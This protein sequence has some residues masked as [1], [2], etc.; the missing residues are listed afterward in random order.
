MYSTPHADAATV[1]VQETLPPKNLLKEKIEKIKEQV[2][3][4]DNY[5][6]TE[7]EQVHRPCGVQTISRQIT[8]NTASSSSELVK[9]DVDVER[10]IVSRAKE[11]LTTATQ[12]TPKSAP[13]TPAATSTQSQ[14]AGNKIDT[15]DMSI[16]TAQI[17]NKIL[18]RPLLIKDLDFTDL[19]I[20]DDIEVTRVSTA[21]PPP[22][23]MM[24]FS[25]F[26]GGPPP[27]PPMNGLAGFAGGPPPPPPPPPP[28]FMGAPPPPPP[29]NFKPMFPQSNTLPANFN[30]HTMAKHNEEADQE[31]RK[32]I[33]LHWREAQIPQS[34]SVARYAAQPAQEESI[35]TNLNH[36]DI[37]REKLAHLFE[38]KQT[39][40]KTKV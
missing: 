35:W 38:L 12:Q 16:D 23:P 29:P 13:A 30:S 4:S 22:P 10:G 1:P 18:N 27:P 36:L 24:G 32:L 7:I 5:A 8:S 11:G 26:A 15:F 9:K 6:R 25:G 17:A 21:P 19:T 33:K 20:H 14:A 3:N 34:H 31:K 37:D 39:E 28:P 40:V 2:S